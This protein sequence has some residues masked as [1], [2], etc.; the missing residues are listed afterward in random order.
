VANNI[1]AAQDTKPTIIIIF[2]KIDGPQFL[3]KAEGMLGG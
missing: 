2:N 1:D 3:I